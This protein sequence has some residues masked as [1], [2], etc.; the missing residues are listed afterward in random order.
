MLGA[1]NN[2]IEQIRLVCLCGSLNVG[3]IILGYQQKMSQ[4]LAWLLGSSR[5]KNIEQTVMLRNSEAETHF[6]PMDDR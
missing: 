4:T 3:D 6:T 2:E 5:D 1:V